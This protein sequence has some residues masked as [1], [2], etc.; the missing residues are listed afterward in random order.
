DVFSSSAMFDD[1]L[2]GDGLSGD[3]VF[4]AILPPM[5][6]N[7]VVEF[8]VSARDPQNQTNTWPAAARQADG[9]T[10]AQTANALYQVDGGT[11][12]GTQPVYRLIMTETE[13]ALLEQINS[14]NPGRNAQ[15]NMTFISLDS[16]N[17]A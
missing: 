13:R 10:F 4:G 16:A 15:M 6:T 11:Y 12:T 1:G 14:S 2:H 17:G 3:G 7:T 9:V 8:Y 5:P